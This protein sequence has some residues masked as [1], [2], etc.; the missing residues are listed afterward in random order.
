[1]STCK[2]GE[3]VMRVHDPGTPAKVKAFQTRQCGPWVRTKQE[4]KATADRQRAEPWS[5]SRRALTPGFEGR[6]GSPWPFGSDPGGGGMLVLKDRLPRHLPASPKVRRPSSCRTQNDL[7]KT[8]AVPSARPQSP[9]PRD[10]GRQNRPP[11]GRIIRPDKSNS[12][13]M[14]L[15]DRASFAP[16][17]DFRGSFRFLRK[18]EGAALSAALDLGAVASG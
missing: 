9:R 16:P 12:A 8:L 5:G 2:P 11:G 1:M 18:S 15:G 6:V 14:S 3:T 13:A 7:G 4:G 10:E 17:R